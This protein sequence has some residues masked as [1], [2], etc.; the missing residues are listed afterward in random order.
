MKSIVCPNCLPEE[1]KHK[2]KRLSGYWDVDREAGIAKC[3]NC[4]YERPFH[5]RSFPEGQMT[6]AQ[7]RVV[8]EIRHAVLHNDGY[9]DNYEYKRFN[10]E[11]TDFGK[12]QVLTEVGRIG[13]EGTMAEV[14]ARTRRQIFIGKRGGLTLCNPAKFI[15]E[16]GKTKIVALERWVKGYKALSHPTV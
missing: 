4:G 3:H 9:G 10:V 1:L 15:E 5:S 14:F 16:N 13:D 11:L 6:T 7:K 2:A 12:V 8:E